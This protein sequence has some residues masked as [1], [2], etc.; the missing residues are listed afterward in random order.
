MTSGHFTFITGA[1]G[2]VDGDGELDLIQLT[3]YDGS[4]FDDQYAYYSSYDDA[5]LQRISLT[6]SLKR[7]LF[8]QLDLCDSVEKAPEPSAKEAEFLDIALQP[9]R[10]YMGSKGDSVYR[11]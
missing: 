10:Q 9:W 4:L 11:V 1:I 5:I 8:K 6:K 3:F 7:R 2:D